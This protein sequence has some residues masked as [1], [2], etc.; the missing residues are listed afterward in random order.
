MTRSYHPPALRPLLYTATIGVM[1]KRKLRPLVI[2]MSPERKQRITDMFSGLDEYF[3]PPVFT[4]GVSSRELRNRI[5]FLEHAYRAGLVPEAE[6][7]EIRRAVKDQCCEVPDDD[8][9]LSLSEMS[10]KRVARAASDNVHL[11]IDPFRYLEETQAPVEK[12]EDKKRYDCRSSKFTVIELWAKAKTLNRGRSVLACVMAHL[13]AMKTLV[14]DQDE[15]ACLGSADSSRFDFI[16]E[17]NVRAFDGSGSECAKRIW[18]AVEASSSREC[19]LRYYGWLGSAPNLTW[20]FKKHIP[21]KAFNRAEGSDFSI[22]P[23]PTNEDFELDGIV[24]RSKPTRQRDK[25]K[26]SNESV[27]SFETPGGTAVWGT[28]AYTVSPK[29]YHTLVRRLQRDVG[30]LMWKGKKMRCFVAKPIDKI[31]P[32]HTRQEFGAQ[33]IHLT[34]KVAFVRAPMLGSLLHPQWEVGFCTSTE[35]Q[36]GL[37]SNEDGIDVWDNVWLSDSEQELIA[38]RKES[39]EWRKPPSKMCPS[40]PPGKSSPQLPT[41]FLLLSVLS[42]ILHE[43]RSF[44]LSK[45][46]LSRPHRVR[47]NTLYGTQGGRRERR[48]LGNMNVRSRDVP[49]GDFN[50]T[51]WELEK[52]SELMQEWWAI[53]E[54]ERSAR[55]GDPF[56][57][58]SWPGSVVASKLLSEEDLT[59]ATVLTLGAGVGVETQAAAILGAR[60]VVATDINPLTLKLL[61]FGA[62]CEERIEDGVVEAMRFD[63]FSNDPLPKSDVIIAADVL[64]NSRLAKRIGKR[65]H[66]AIVRS[67]DEGDAPVKLIVTDS[68]SFHGTDFLQEPEL[69][70][71]N[72]MFKEE[73]WEELRWEDTKCRFCGSGVMI[74]ADQVYD[75]DVRTMKWGF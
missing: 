6:W 11:I 39:G 40:P 18:Q 20:V 17:D 32:R 56:G 22:F 33:T 71:L 34:S 46:I 1:M 42:L 62:D 45:C 30:A 25:T 61:K 73:S 57:V 41:T 7:S 4:A 49:L 29:T 55:V 51:V 3:E 60:H 69:K 66:E 38:H 10:E 70:D 37:S 27:P 74:D 52:P 26:D 36:H 31:L 35:L 63:L 5:K 21:R 8:D 44:R 28:F 65:I 13:M 19:H 24:S 75:V 23:L 2:T 15:S 59:N 72:A 14:G 53:D 58:V 47:Q 50:V 64:Y 68:Q 48:R 67:F 43:A 16:L 12:G 54:D 9:S